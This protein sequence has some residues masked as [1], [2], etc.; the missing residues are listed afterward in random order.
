MRR[1]ACVLTQSP[2]RLVA[3]LSFGRGHSLDSVEWLKYERI[4]RNRGGL[5]GLM[6]LAGFLVVWGVSGEIGLDVDM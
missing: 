3:A 4:E 2:E 5:T 6:F 1:A